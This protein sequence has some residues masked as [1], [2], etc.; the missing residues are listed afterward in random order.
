MNI[1]NSAGERRPS[2]SP[3]TPGLNGDDA[4]ALL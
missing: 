2:T 4:P 1:T 3:S